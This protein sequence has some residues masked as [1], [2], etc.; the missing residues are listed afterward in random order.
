MYGSKLGECWCI[1]IRHLQPKS[2]IEPP[3]KANCL[4]FI[5]VS[6]ICDID[7]S[8]LHDI[9]YPH[10]HEGI[11]C[12]HDTCKHMSYVHVYLYIYMYSKSICYTLRKREGERE[13]ADK[14]SR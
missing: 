13:R 14:I 4:S 9:F 5:R 6:F 11:R 3:T 12:T 2:S 7:T 1:Y 8:N 10:G